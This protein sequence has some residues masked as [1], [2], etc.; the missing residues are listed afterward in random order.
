MGILEKADTI[1]LEEDPYGASYVKT[2]LQFLLQGKQVMLLDARNPSPYRQKLKEVLDPAILP[3]KGSLIFLT[4]G[5]SSTPKGVSLSLSALLSQAK[6]FSEI[7]G[8]GDCYNPLPQ[9]HIGGWMASFRTLLSGHRLFLKQKKEEAPVLPFHSSLR[10]F[11]VPTQV[12]KSLDQNPDFLKSFKF[13][14]IGG[15][16]SSSLLVER[17]SKHKIRAIFAYGLTESASTLATTRPCWKKNGSYILQGPSALEALPG[18][19]LK[20]LNGRL[21]FRS[22]SMF[23]GFWEKGLF[24]KAPLEKDGYFLTS[25]LAQ[26]I[27]PR[28]KF[29]ILGR[30]DLNFQSG[31]INCNPEEIEE[32]LEGS[33]KAYF[34]KI[35]II[36]LPSKKWGKEVCALYKTS[37]HFRGLLRALPQDKI[38]EA[39]SLWPPHFI[40]K[41]WFPLPEEEGGIKLS[42][43]KLKIY[44]LE[45]L[46]A[47]SRKALSLSQRS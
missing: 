17:L 46:K 38:K 33:L 34:E 29:K 3:Q 10:A 8:K 11:M 12:E 4:S 21:A 45:Q 9:N 44:A 20:I 2:S 1:Y 30:A 15:A 27:L 24:Q 26:W 7:F 25:D 14:V 28:Q 41:I 42:R 22:C 43:H 13:T 18:R 5:T 40:P 39:L 35:R 37:Q 47:S 32:A 19:Q 6:S 31:G 36:P 23:D 16:P